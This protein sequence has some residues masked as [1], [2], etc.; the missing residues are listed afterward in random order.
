VWVIKLAFKP[1]SL[2][3]K[4]SL[5]LGISP[6]GIPAAIGSRM[7]NPAGSDKI[8]ITH[9]HAQLQKEKQYWYIDSIRNVLDIMLDPTPEANVN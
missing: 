1:F 6:V 3:C 2:L 8:Y 9:Q 7:S 4:A 5:F